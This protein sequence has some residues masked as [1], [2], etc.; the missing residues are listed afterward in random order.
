VVEELK[1]EISEW[2]DSIPENL[3]GGGKADEVS[4]A[5]DELETI[6]SEMENID[7]GQVEFPGLY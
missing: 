4:S 5:L 7:F 3:Q 2:Q 1:D 6:L